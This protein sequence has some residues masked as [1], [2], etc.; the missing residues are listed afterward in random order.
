MKIVP[1]RVSNEVGGVR[2]A[3]TFIMDEALEKERQQE[4]EDGE[5]RKRRRNST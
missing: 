3:Q 1:Q 2:S 4:D 5:K